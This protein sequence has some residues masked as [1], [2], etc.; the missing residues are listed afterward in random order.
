MAL[1]KKSEFKQ[2]DVKQLKDK[3]IELKKDLLK[4]NGQRATG[5]MESPGRMKVVKKTIARIYTMLH[6]K[7]MT[8][9]METKKHTGGTSKK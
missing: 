9:P 3:L 7:K 6:Q 8:I 5:T 1:I 4:L 2:L